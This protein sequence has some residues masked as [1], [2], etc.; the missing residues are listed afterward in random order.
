MTNN[1]LQYATWDN[2]E[3]ECEIGFGLRITH[4]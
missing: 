3:N 4:N 2:F 1:Q